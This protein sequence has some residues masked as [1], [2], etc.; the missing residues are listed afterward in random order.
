MAHVR[1][2]DLDGSLQSPAGV[3]WP[4]GTGCV[5]AHEWGPLIRLACTFGTF[6]RFE[7]WLGESLP[8]SART[9]RFMALATFITSLL[10]SYAGFTGRSTCFCST[11][12][13][14]G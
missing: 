5:P 10:P 11:S 8:P 14:T 2:L 9:S 3:R 6:E 1:V 12:I 7:K 4:A 13:R